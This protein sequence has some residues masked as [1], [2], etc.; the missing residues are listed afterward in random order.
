MKMKREA[1][2]VKIISGLKKFWSGEIRRDVELAG[3]TTLKIGGPALALIVPETMV[4][5]ASLINGCRKVDIPWCVVG[6]GSNLLVPDEGFPG[7]V[8]V[9]GRKFSAIRK[10]G[11]DKEGRSL[12]EVEAGCSL[13]AFINWTC[14]QRLAGLEF[15]AG[16]PGTIGGA[17]I[18][19]AGAWGSEIKDVLASMSWLENGEIKSCPRTDLVFKYRRWECSP[20]AVVLTATFALVESDST[21]IK[22]H[23]RENIEARRNKQPL[24]T[25]N[26]G[27]FFR[28]PPVAPAGKLIEEAGLK[29]A[30]IGGAEVSL[31]HANFIVNN[32]GATAGDVIGLMKVVQ[33]K[34]KEVHNIWLEP[35]VRILGDIERTA[36]E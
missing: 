21:Q 13:A 25:A 18:M 9:L 27:S 35:E 8:M 11:F 22:Q 2:R 14:E 20:E 29:G 23:C 24:A 12:V 32:G 5:I 16:I 30:K 19:N 31:V 33:E 34:V 6:G 17:V 36:D 10:V 4:E 28:N 26:A 3:F 1:E 7:V 15:S